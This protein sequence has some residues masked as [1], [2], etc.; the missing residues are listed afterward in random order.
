MNLSNIENP[1]EKIKIL[2]KQA[3]KNKEDKITKLNSDIESIKKQK[4]DGHIFV[5]LEQEPEFNVTYVGKAI[6]TIIGDILY[7]FGKGV[8]LMKEDIDKQSGGNIAETN[9][10]INNNNNISK[11]KIQ[12]NT[13]ELSQVID[14]AQNK[15]NNTSLAVDTN[16]SLNETYSK[17]AELGETAFKSGLKWTEEFI[18]MIID[19]SLDSTGQS[20]VNDI[21]WQELSPQLNKKLVLMAGLLRELSDNP[22]T[23]EAV[24]EIAQAIAIT[25]VE[26][27]KEIK[28]ELDKV[29]EQSLEMLDEVSEKAVRGATQT[30][31]SVG[32]AF[33]AEIPFWGG[34]IDFIIAIGKGF[35]AVAE[36]YKVFVTKSSPI[37]VDSAQAYVNTEETVER[38]KDRISNAYDNAMNNLTNASN[39]NSEM[40]SET[41]NDDNITNNTNVMKGGVFI[42][43]KNIK[44]KILKGGNRLKKT[45][46]LFHKTIPRVTYKN[47]DHKD[48]HYR[49][50][51]NY[52]KRTKTNKKRK[53][54]TRKHNK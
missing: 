52:H 34:I 28:P 24:K 32:Q 22:A 1:D 39:M 42:P 50:H 14:K 31:L 7:G 37:M 40:N 53:H 54:N 3:I 46:K 29:T 36:T 11:E 51:G 45:M 17:A 27:M 35:N 43:N 30:G 47:N 33:I 21:S 12:N 25:M 13:N 15:A 44:N 5:P 4:N 20:D 2:L 38:G 48:N 23:R 10:S 9:N 18:N 8:Q 6:T 19:L 16:K 41:N 49:K 26:I